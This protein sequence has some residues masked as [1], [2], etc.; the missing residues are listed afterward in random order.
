[1]PIK[2]PPARN[3]PEVPDLATPL[4]SNS[5]SIKCAGGE[6]R[7]DHVVLEGGK[8][9]GVH[10]LVVDTGKVRAALIPTRGLSLWRAKH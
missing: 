4:S 9:A 1:M 7:I 3:A 5:Q 6:F 8:R 10:V 2:L